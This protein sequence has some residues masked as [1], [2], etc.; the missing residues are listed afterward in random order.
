MLPVRH[1]DKSGKQ[2][3]YRAAGITAQLEDRLSQT[4]P[5]AG[6]HVGHAGCFGMKY[7]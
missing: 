3:A 7:G 6:S 4:A 5:V 1:N 2:R